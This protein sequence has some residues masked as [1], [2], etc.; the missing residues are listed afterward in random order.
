MT[1]FNFG[2]VESGAGGAVVIDGIEVECVAFESGGLGQAGTPRFH[3]W[4]ETDQAYTTG[5]VDGTPFQ[6]GDRLH[7][8]GS[9]SE[10]WGTAWTQDDINAIKVSVRNQF[11]GGNTT[12][13]E[14][15]IDYISINVHYN[16]GSSTGQSFSTAFDDAD[17]PAAGYSWT[18]FSNLAVDDTSYARTF[19]E[20]TTPAF[21]KHLNATD[22][23]TLI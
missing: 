15:S 18:A 9:S 14:L 8:V 4:N 22:F 19:F 16:S 21:F 3:L 12:F 23:G 2:I 13:W 17:G 6:S 5:M 11:Q 20:S 1:K 10:L 7:D